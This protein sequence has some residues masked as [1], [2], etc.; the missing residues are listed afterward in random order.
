[1]RPP[2]LPTSIITEPTERRFM[3]PGGGGAGGGILTIIE[4]TRKDLIFDESTFRKKLQNHYYQNFQT[5]LSLD[6]I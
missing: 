4:L 6:V 5:Y 3:Y 1:M 2:P